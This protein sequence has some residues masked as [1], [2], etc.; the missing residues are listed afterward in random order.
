MCFVWFSR[1]TDAKP[2]DDAGDAPPATG[3]R[4]R[5]RSEK[6][7]LIRNWEERYSPDKTGG[8]RLS[9]TLVYGATGEEDGLDD[10][11]EGNVRTV[12]PDLTL[13]ATLHLQ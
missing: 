7:G 8:L 13:D 12:S 3:I 2:G 11:R 10:R 9:K 6:V 1:A 4:C 5:R